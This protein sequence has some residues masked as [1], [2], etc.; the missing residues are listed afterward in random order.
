[1]LTVLCLCH[2]YAHLLLLGVLSLPT[3]ST[4]VSLLANCPLAVITCFP[5]VHGKPEVPKFLWLLFTAPNLYLIGGEVKYSRP[6]GLGLNWATLKCD[7]CTISRT[8]PVVH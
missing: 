2:F 3:A 6:L 4:C 7:L 5:C 8:F 1:M